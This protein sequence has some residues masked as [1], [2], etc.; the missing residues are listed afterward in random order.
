VPRVMA[1]E[2][3]LGQVFLNLFQNAAQ[4]IDPGDGRSHRILVRT[5]TDEGGHAVVEVHDTGAGIAPENLGRIFDP[6]FTTRPIGAGTGHGRRA[7]RPVAG[8]RRR[9]QRGPGLSSGCCAGLAICRRIASR[10]GGTIVATSELGQGAKFI[11]DLPLSAIA[12]TQRPA[13]TSSAEP[14]RP[15]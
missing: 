6:F 10:H 12:P 9:A 13:A 11:V 2:S 14:Y 8:G 5:S 7:P 1:N 4:A 3:R 15:S